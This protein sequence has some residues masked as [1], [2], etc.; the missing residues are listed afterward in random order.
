M[1]L[2]ML[3]LDVAGDDLGV[4]RIGLG[5]FAD[6]LAVVTHVARVEQVHHKATGMRQFGQQ[7]V[8]T[9]GRLQADVRTG[10]QVIKPVEQRGFAV[11][12]RLTT[13][14]AKDRHLQPILAHVD[15]DAVRDLNALCHGAKWARPGWAHLVAL[16]RR[17]SALAG[18]RFLIEYDA[19]QNEGNHI[20]TVWRDFDGDFGRD[21]LR[22]H[23]AMTQGT[24]HRH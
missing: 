21:L 19:S 5:P 23:H 4:D 12:K 16:A 24:S 10:W 18:A 22:E 13:W 14:C 15:A 7:L 20:H 9:P 17:K 8:V 3:A 2:G 11:G 1:Q 6:A